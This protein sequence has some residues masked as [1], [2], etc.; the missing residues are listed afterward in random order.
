[1]EMLR[2]FY[3]IFRD[4]FYRKHFREIRFISGTITYRECLLI[5]YYLIFKRNSIVDGAHIKQYEHKFAKY[6]GVK[7][8]FSFGAGRMAFYSLL[9]SFGVADGDEVILP[10]YTCVVVPAAIVYCGAKPIYVDIDPDTLCIDVDKIED[11]ITPRTKVIYAQHMFASFCDM[12]AISNLAKRYNLKVI[13]DCAHALGAEYDGKKAGTFGDAAYFTTEQSKIISTGMGGMVVANDDVLAESLL[14]IQ[15][16]ADF[17]E[18]NTIEKICLQIIAYNVFLHPWVAFIGKYFLYLINKYGLMM[19]ST[20]CDE[21]KCIM[22]DKYPVKLSNIQ[23]RIG[24]MQ[25]ERIGKNIEHRRKIAHVYRKSLKDTGIKLYESND[26]LYEPAYIRYALLVKNRDN[27]RKI[28]QNNQIELGEWFNS[29][30]HPK[31]SSFESVYYE[32]GSCPIAEDIV[33]HNVNL[34]THLKVKKSGA[35]RCISILID[36]SRGD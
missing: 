34:P 27:L 13:E 20:T 1:M 23:A 28:F 2:K 18:K 26:E 25:L 22:P 32:L 29:V 9:K 14:K 30:I 10:G 3:R 5:L 15:M 33:K 24:L 17:L 12:E 16:D 7:H 35:V 31:G 11:K 8:A 21:M 4:I 19:E 6:L 36:H